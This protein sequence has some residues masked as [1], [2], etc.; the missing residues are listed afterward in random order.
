MIATILESATNVQ[1]NHISAGY[2]AGLVIA[3]LILAYMVFSLIK[4]EKF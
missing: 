2:F 1:V 3:F 4:P